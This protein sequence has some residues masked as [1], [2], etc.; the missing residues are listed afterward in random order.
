MKRLGWINLVGVLVL[1]SLCAG[2]WRRDRRLHLELRQEE[3]R[4]TALEQKLAEQDK[5]AAGLTADLARFK[6]QFLEAHTN[7]SGARSAQRRLEQENVQLTREREQLKASVTNWAVAVAARD[8]SLR[9]LNR[10]LEEST[11]QLHESVLRHNEL[12]S[13]YN[14][15]VRRFNE[16]ATNYNSVVTQLNNLR[17]V[18]A[19]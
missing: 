5:S 16:L 11:G 17:T 3:V 15:T 6:S 7:A 19:K 9:E 1:A 13:N 8:E 4:R 10:R 18:P 14:A 2:Q 12:A